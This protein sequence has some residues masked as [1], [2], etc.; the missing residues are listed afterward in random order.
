[1]KKISSFF[2]RIGNWCKNH[3]TA[4]A[5]IITGLFVLS[6]IPF[7]LNHEIWSDEAIPW[8]I[9]KQINLGNIYE[10]NDAEPHPLLWEIILAPF[11]QNN[12]PVITLN[13]ISLV[14]VSLAVFLLVR[15]APFNLFVKII[16]I[17]SNAFF[18][19][20]PVIARDY[21]LIPLAIVLIGIFYNKRHERSLIYGLVLA[22]LAQTHFLMYGLLGIL[23]LGF[24]VEEIK[25]ERKIG[26]TILNIL[27]ILVPLGLSVV[28]V[29]PMVFGSLKNQAI[30][31]G[32]AFENNMVLQL[33]LSSSIEHAIFGLDNTVLNIMAIVFMV[34]FIVSLL[35]ENVK[36]AVYAIV[37]FAF[38]FF[39]MGVIYRGYQTFEQKCSILTLFVIISA[40]ILTLE[41][42]KEKENVFS[43]ILNFSEIIKF[44]RLHIRNPSVVFMVIL[45]MMTIPHAMV[46]AFSDLELPF[47]S[48]KENAEF[49][50]SL[51]ENSVIVEGD[52]PAYNQIDVATR[53]QIT[54]K[55]VK[56]YNMMFDSLIDHN[57]D[58]KYNNQYVEELYNMDLAAEDKTIAKLDEL[59]LEYENVY[60]MQSSR[61]TSCSGFEKTIPDWLVKYKL[62]TELDYGRY[63]EPGHTPT[64]VFKIK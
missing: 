9:S 46:N 3:K 12:F 6:Q 49:I 31:T 63:K 26:K 29:L 58:L 41:P 27:K 32:A 23:S 33:S 50:N 8:E 40:W 43:K 51:P 1:M 59:S 19:Y 48:S 42:K 21:C 52:F 35:S 53:S 38:W 16:F 45:T 34:L 4:V 13:I 37:S 2:Q 18:Y 24:I 61:R 39:V 44:L 55:D 47:T 22:F 57:I 25:S 15:F 56:F 14:I 11:S 7:L 17:L 62:V 5:L 64:L 36:V 30:M 10:L 20:N 54:N 60:Y 28:T